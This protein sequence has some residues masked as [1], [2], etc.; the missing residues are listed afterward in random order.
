MS[1]MHSVTEYNWGKVKVDY[2][3]SDIRRS[4]GGGV[5]PSNGLV[6]PVTATEKEERGLISKG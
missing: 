6:L 2:G 3:A 4:E 5:T 1:I